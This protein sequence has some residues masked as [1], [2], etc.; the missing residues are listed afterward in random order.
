MT[1]AGMILGTAAYMS[2]EQARGKPVDKR[3][4]ER[5]IGRHSIRADHMAGQHRKNGNPGQFAPGKHAPAFARW[6]TAGHIHQRRPL[7]VR[8]GARRH[9]PDHH[10][11]QHQSSSRLD[12]RREAPGV[13]Q[14]GGDFAIW[15][16]RFDG[17]MEPQKLLGGKGL[18][19]PDSLSPDGQRLA[20]LQPRTGDRSDIFTLPL[21]VRDPGHPKPGEPEPF[22]REPAGAFDAAFS[23]DGH[24]M[25]Y[26]TFRTGT[27]QV[28]VQPYPSGPSAGRW[29][30]SN[31]PGRFPVWA[32]N[33]RELLFLSN[34]NRIMTAS[35]TIQGG[36][37]AADKPRQW[38]PTA[39]LR[40]GNLQNFDLA[41]DGKRV[42]AF[43]VPM[44]DG[45]DAKSPVHVTV[46]LNFFDELRR[47]VK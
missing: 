22:L 40:T 20:F 36:S 31:T 35:Y 21:D 23:P 2:P 45:L 42:I 39:I 5:Q 41:P 26:A 27:S 7:G 33:G 1:Q 32:R 43:P 6:Q 25:A 44:A 3:A 19:V 24:W 18:L 12:C 11:R 16:V 29:Q 14:E 9:Q 28:F 34:D 30:I 38:S 46:L 37:F 17:S 10:Q 13:R 4:S 47:R 15:W 8:S